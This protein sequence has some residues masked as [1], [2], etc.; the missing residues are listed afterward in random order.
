[1]YNKLV[2]V[3]HLLWKEKKKGKGSSELSEG[4]ELSRVSLVRVTAETCKKDR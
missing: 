4:Q 3:W 1:M 2:D